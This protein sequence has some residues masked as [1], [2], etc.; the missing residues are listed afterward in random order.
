VNTDSARQYGR[1]FLLSGF[2]QD[3]K[4]ESLTALSYNDTKRQGAYDEGWLQRLIAAHP[5]IL[6]FEETEPALGEAVSV[7]TE[8][9]VNGNFLDN[10]LATDRGDLVLVECKLW[11]NPE[12]R[13][14]VIGQILDYATEIASW[15]Y[16]KLDNAV[17]QARP[18]PGHVANERERN[19]CR[20]RRSR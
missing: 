1:P 14:K 7:C 18:A 16:E 4:A 9:P 3:S 19:E 6:P 17:T 2:G 15:D 10:L 8:L 12:A 5:E 11:R 20:G 13:R